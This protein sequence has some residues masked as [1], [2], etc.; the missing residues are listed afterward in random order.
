MTRTVTEGSELVWRGASSANLSRV[1]V[2]DEF[3]RSRAASCELV[4]FRWTGAPG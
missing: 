4:M 1:P 3:T 2:R